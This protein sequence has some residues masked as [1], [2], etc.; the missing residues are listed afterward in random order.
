M[1]FR[2]FRPSDDLAVEYVDRMA[3]GLI[4]KAVFVL[5]GT[6]R[7]TAHHLPVPFFDKSAGQ[8]LSTRI[9]LLLRILLCP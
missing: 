8:G 4:N 9:E 2:T 1:D 5:Y 3:A 7:H 6:E